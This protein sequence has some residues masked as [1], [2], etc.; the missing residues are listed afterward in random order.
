MARYL[1]SVM[2]LLVVACVGPSSSNLRRTCYTTNGS[3]DY[4]GHNQFKKQLYSIIDAKWLELR[5]A[6][7]DRKSTYDSAF[8][9]TRSYLLGVINAE[10]QPVMD[11]SI[12]MTNLRNIINNYENIN[13]TSG[14][15]DHK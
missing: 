3:I 12:I 14:I 10:G 6:G 13:P 2:L 4:K 15:I 9:Y 7:F 5:R 8:H 11:T 1:L